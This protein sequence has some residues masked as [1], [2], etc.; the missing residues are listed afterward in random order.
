MEIRKLILGAALLLG[1]CNGKEGGGPVDSAVADLLGRWIVK[2]TAI[3]GTFKTK[4]SAGKDSVRNIDTAF[5]EAGETYF[6]EL[7]GDRSYTA[8]MPPVEFYLFRILGPGIFGKRAAAQPI[9]GRWSADGRTITTVSDGGD[10]LVLV[11]AI[12]GSEG[13]FTSHVEM[14]DSTFEAV[15]DVTYSGTKK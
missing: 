15:G 11:A 12:S 4:D 3:K 5:T 6:V 14:K 13:S 7:K 1:A 10:T 9:N 8:E 2:K